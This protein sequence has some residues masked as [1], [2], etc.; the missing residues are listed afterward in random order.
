MK[1]EDG[2][3]EDQ[4]SGDEKKPPGEEKPMKTGDEGTQP[5][6]TEGTGDGG[7]EHEDDLNLKDKKG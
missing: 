2:I 3:D 6:P 4:K 5:Q 1:N 7:V